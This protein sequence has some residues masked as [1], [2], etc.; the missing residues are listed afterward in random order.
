MQNTKDGPYATSRTTRQ[1]QVLFERRRI[2]PGAARDFAA[3]M[4]CSVSLDEGTG[5]G[6]SCPQQLPNTSSRQLVEALG[7]WCHWCFL[8]FTKLPA[9]RGHSCPQQLPHA[10][11][12]QLV[13]AL[14]HWCHW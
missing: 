13:E 11:T 5:R 9:E 7:H 10:S 4:A 2:G 12:R 1:K 14:S 6:H 8:R 3:R